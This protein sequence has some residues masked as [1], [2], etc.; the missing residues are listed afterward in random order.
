VACLGQKSDPPMTG[1]G[2]SA[3][4]LL[5]A[6]IMQL[7]WQGKSRYLPIQTTCICVGFRPGSHQRHAFVLFVRGLQNSRQRE[8]HWSKSAASSWV[9]P[10]V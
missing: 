7:P 9:A 8:L 6:F 4:G 1:H 2:L 5:V 10:S 3:I